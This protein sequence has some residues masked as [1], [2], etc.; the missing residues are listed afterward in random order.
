MQHVFAVA[1]RVAALLDGGTDP[2]P[3]QHGLTTEEERAASTS[4][5]VDRQ[6]TCHLMCCLMDNS[7]LDVCVAPALGQS[8]AAD[9][10]CGLS[11]LADAECKT[12]SLQ[13]AHGSQYCCIHLK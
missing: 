3:A 1:R 12:V 4:A 9:V 7:T 10:L 13:K 11:S 2:D 5:Q 8:P 6:S